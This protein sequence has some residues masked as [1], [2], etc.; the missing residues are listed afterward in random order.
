VTGV[1]PHEARCTLTDAETGHPID[2]PPLS[3]RDGE[4]VIPITVP[5]PGVYRIEVSG[6]GTSPVTQLLMAV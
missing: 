1:E 3:R 5:A 6:G 4:V 2:H